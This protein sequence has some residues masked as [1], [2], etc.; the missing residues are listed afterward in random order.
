MPAG[1]LDCWQEE[2]TNKTLEEAT[3]L[4]EKAGCEIRVTNI[5]GNEYDVP[6]SFVSSRVNVS[7]VNNIVIEVT[8][9]S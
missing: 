9:L 5:D 2:L 7:I 8:S 3:N 4:V 1:A 6:A